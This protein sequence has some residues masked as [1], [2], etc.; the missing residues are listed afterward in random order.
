[1][2]VYIYIYIY[3]ERERERERERRLSGFLFF[4]AIHR[5]RGC[6]FEQSSM[7]NPNYNFHSIRRG[8]GGKRKGIKKK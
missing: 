4:Y 5:E 8:C 6:G 7:L 3:R 1:V 2:C